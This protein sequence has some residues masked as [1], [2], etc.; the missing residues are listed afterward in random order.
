MKS[1]RVLPYLLDQLESAAKKK[2]MSAREWA[3]A[4]DVRPET[5]SR[6]RKRGDCDLSTLAALAHAAGMQLTARAEPAEPAALAASLASHVPQRYGRD[7]EEQLLQLCSAAN[8]DLNAW[9]VAGPSF[10]MAGLATMLAGARGF[11]RKA[12]LDLA[13]AL[14]PGATTPEALSRWFSISPVK[15]SRFLPMLQ[16]RRA[17]AA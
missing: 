10:F 8:P 12:Y 7:E 17:H 14:H 11:E 13:E 2:G 5:I 6:L 16:V 9:R 3:T 1:T 4:A 15:P